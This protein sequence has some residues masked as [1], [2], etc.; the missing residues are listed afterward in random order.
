MGVYN[1]TNKRLR[2]IINN[3]YGLTKMH[4]QKIDWWFA[5]SYICI[6]EKGKP[7]VITVAP[8]HVLCVIS[9]CTPVT[10]RL[11]QLETPGS[12]SA[13][14]MSLT[15]WIQSALTWTW[16]SLKV[17]PM[18]TWCK[19]QATCRRRF[20]WLLAAHRCRAL[21]PWPQISCRRLLHLSRLPRRQCQSPHAPKDSGTSQNA[22]VYEYKINTM[23]M[24]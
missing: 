9:P 19:W 7:S 23:D 22:H 24:Y 8:E 14:K 4:L 17:M 10:W 6:F 20:P 2:N 15:L 16:V 5:H 3:G 12:P 13:G 11:R 1:F 18:A 21:A